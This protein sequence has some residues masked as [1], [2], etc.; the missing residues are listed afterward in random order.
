M[1]SLK[2]EHVEPR[3]GIEPE[4]GFDQDLAPSALSRR[5]FMQVSAASIAFATLGACTRAPAE[6]IVPYRVQPSEIVPGRALHYASASTL[7][8]YATGILVESHEGR[9]TKIEGNPEHPASLGASSAIEQALLLELYDPRRL[10]TIQQRGAPASALEPLQAL[11]AAAAVERK[12]SGVHLILPA[13]SSPLVVDQLKRLRQRLPELALYFHAPLAPTNAWQ[14]AKLAFGRVLDTRVD[15]RRANVVL[16][17]GADFLA[18]GPAQLALAGAFAER[19]APDSPA[20]PMNRLYAVE[21]APSVTGSTADHRLALAP[22]QIAAFAS[23]LLS[24]VARGVDGQ[25]SA[26]FATLPTPALSDDA[27]RFLA[28]LSADLLAQRGASAVLAGDE[29]P[30]A[31]HAAAHALNVLLG[32]TGSVMS[33]APPVVFAADDPEFG[34]L[35]GLREALAADRVRTL[36]SFESDIAFS[37]LELRGL[38]SKA[39]ESLCFALFPTQTAALSSWQIPSAHALETWGDA[40]AFDGTASIVQPL[41]APLYGGRTLSEVLAVLLGEEPN[42]AHDLVKNFWQGRHPDDFGEFWELALARGVVAG[43]LTDAVI[44]PLLEPGWFPEL[45]SASAGPQGIELNLESD[46]RVHDGRFGTNSWLLELPCPITKLTWENAAWL[47]PSLARR[48]AVE[49]GDV[50]RLRAGAQS[51]EVPA[52]IVPGHADGA[53]SLALGWGRENEA[54]KPIGVNAFALRA[55]NARTVN[56]ERSG[57]QAELAITQGSMQLGDLAESILVS[58]TLSQYRAERPARP[59]KKQLSLYTSDAPESARQWGMVIDLNAC[60]GCSACVIACQAENNVP[61]V[62]KGGVLKHREMHWLRIDRYLIEEGKTERALVQPMACQHCE[63]APCEYVCPTAATVHSSDGLNQMIYNRCVGTRFC[64]NNCP[65]KVR[66]FNWF[67]YHQGE[68]S[69]RELAENPEVT[70]RARGVMEKC[71]YCVQRIRSAENRAR[72]EH[73]PLRDGDVRTAC[74]QACPTRAI[75]F[76]DVNDPHSAVARL[77]QNPRAFEVL[78]EIGTAPRTRYLM[79]LTNPNPELT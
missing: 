49:A 38:L 14:G 51:L 15:L 61:S 3:A 19:R 65:Y 20:N 6:K 32:N 41:I 54:G 76:G 77:R 30:P 22:T 55:A 5:E 4:F 13:Q 27:A 29:Q 42:S 66:R 45:A 35:R 52:L 7:D 74:E 11:R 23:A 50:I 17:L 57:R 18:R 40:L 69:P 39:K 43:T 63:H 21:T 59:I 12:G 2:H 73:R 31:V 9:P 25:A 16:A 33:H 28:A 47:A 68:R 8:G 48:L 34:S 1:S 37:D 36:I 79:K 24:A 71:S 46:T 10:R 44:A 72:V 53:I 62:G 58:S 26:A 60:T 64:S 75:S 67:N 78:A 56:V 70:V